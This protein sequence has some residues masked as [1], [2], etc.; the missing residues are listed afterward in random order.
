MCVTAGGVGG[1]GMS[2]AGDDGGRRCRS[3]T[4]A[5]AVAYDISSS[6]TFPSSIS[7]GGNSSRKTASCGGPTVFCEPLSPPPLVLSSPRPFIR[8]LLTT[9][10]RWV[11]T[12]HPA[13]VQSPRPKAAA[14]AS[15]PGLQHAGE[16]RGIEFAPTAVRVGAPPTAAARPPPLGQQRPTPHFAPCLLQKNGPVL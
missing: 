16:R 6:I 3:Q 10:A 2:A 14:L 4:V 8:S 12:P 9:L 7:A 15:Q 11:P 1:K 13:F 5:M